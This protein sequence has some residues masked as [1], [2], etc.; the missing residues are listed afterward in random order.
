MRLAIMQAYFFPYIGYFQ[1]IDAVDKYLLY[2]NLDYIKD[3]W[4][5]RNRIQGKNEAPFYF[6][7][8]VTGKS[9]NRRISE[10]ALVEAPAWRR[11]LKNALALNYR[12][13]AFFE[14][15]FALVEP[16]LDNPEQS[17]HGYNA[18]IIRGLCKHLGIETPIVSDNQK[19][20]VL[21]Q[22]LDAEEEHA[23]EG[24]D[25]VKKVR[26]VLRIC[27]E[28]GA[29]MFVNAIGGTSLYREE[30]FHKE[31]LALR[32]VQ[33]EALHYSQFHE[34]FTPHL[35]ILDVLMFCGR[36]GTRELLKRYSLV[37]GQE[38]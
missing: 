10:I 24:L 25:P 22:E 4:M 7:T 2:E 3:G 12:G 18:I 27:K 16:L 37:R 17:L 19:Y 36:E 13:A 29:A 38:A 14:E 15:T 21:E 30:A 9:S 35:S 28:E 11:K 32:F 33:T 1:A 6:A 20:L 23:P 5:H 8:Q 26:R 34:P 31:G